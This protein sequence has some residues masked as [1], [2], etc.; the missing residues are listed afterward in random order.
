[1]RYLELTAGYRTALADGTLVPDSPKHM[2]TEELYRAYPGEWLRLCDDRYLLA[3]AIFSM[4]REPKYIY[5]Y[6][7]HPEEIWAG[8]TKNL[9]P[10][11]YGQEDYV[12]GQ[13][14]W[15]RVCVRRKDGGDITEEDTAHAKNL[16]TLDGDR[17][18]KRLGEEPKPWFRMEIAKTVEA[19]KSVAAE[20]N[21]AGGRTRIMKLCLLTDTHA[22]VNGTWEDTACNIRSVARQVDYDAIVHMGDFTDGMLSKRLTEKYVN[23]ILDDLE[24]CQVPVYAAVGNHDSNYFR[25]RDNTYTVEEMC[26]IYRLGCEGK[27]RLDYFVD[28]PEHS[29][30]MIFL[31]S[32]DDR[33]R[34]RYGYTKEQ[35][36]WLE[37]VVYSS[38]DGTR[39][40]IFSHD[41][42]LAKLD[43][44]SFHMRNGEALLDILEG[45]NSTGRYQVVGFFYGHTHADYIFGECSFPVI[46]VGCA[47]LEYFTDKKP[48]GA[49]A[50]R[51]EA[52]TVTQDLWDSV[53]IDFEA[54][55]VR[56]VR[57]G[58]GE[59][60]EVSFAKKESIYKKIEILRRTNRATKVWA[61]RGASGHA[62]ENTVPA[63]ELAHLLGADGIELDVQLS[64]DGV[65]VV[66]HDEQIDRVSDGVGNVRDFTLE[67]LRAFNMNVQFP[68]YGRVAIPTL[69]EVYDLVKGTQ[70]VVNLELKN[71]VVF[72]EGLEERVLELARE[73][74]LEDRVIYS[75]FNH[76]SMRRMKRL[77]PSARV[78]FL[79][80][81]GILDAAEYA[82]RNG[83][84]AIHPSLVN[85]GY[86]GVDVVRECHERGVRVHVWTVNET[87]DIEK[88]KALGADAVI[89]NYVERG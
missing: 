54:Q 72:Y 49:V 45:C 61:H 57:F 1:M 74:G 78:A 75:S 41:A 9:T 69:S 34:I 44:W 29:V 86:P 51:R 2:A 11:S 4:E 31:S 12:F 46:S 65:P 33:E 23:R 28:V 50:W 26:R 14:C 27:N 40:L 30:R 59:D 52:D 16:V 37:E 87:A 76:Y 55:K 71:S 77:L 43:Y 36:R 32:F 60:R 7:Y 42:P 17:D 80:S 66:I 22:A 15:F 38:E 68:A 5:S 70:M 67:E 89:T 84:F 25:N 3:P 21:R 82:R 88:M 56:I 20:G 47:K 8:Y 6:A 83:V 24:A 64:K 85:M 39:F 79:Y 81:D 35:L 10:D 62:P 63:F 53:L 73:K 18:G 13:D 19:I 58:A 48:K